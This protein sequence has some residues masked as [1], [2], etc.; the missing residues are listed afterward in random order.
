MN[1][2]AQVSNRTADSL[3]PRSFAYKNVENVDGRAVR[4]RGHSSGGS[5][6]SHESE[7]RGG[8]SSGNNAAVFGRAVPTALVSL[9]V[10][11]DVIFLCIG[12][13]EL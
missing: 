7:G 6:S 13:V 8:S 9:T 1:Q 2:F 10:V 4:R 12:M 11:I 3:V 5:H